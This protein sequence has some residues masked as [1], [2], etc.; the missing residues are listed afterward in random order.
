VLSSVFGSQIPRTK[1][2]VF[3]GCSGIIYKGLMFKEF[4][5]GMKIKVLAFELNPGRV[6]FQN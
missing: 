6:D 3:S 2:R 5:P 4:S 1:I